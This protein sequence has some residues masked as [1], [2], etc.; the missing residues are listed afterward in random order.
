[1]LSDRAVVVPTGIDLE[2]W[3]PGPKRADGPM[4]ILFV[5]GQFD[6]KGGAV[7]LEAFDHLDRGSAE[8]HVVT[9]STLEPRP[10]VVVH[11][12]VQPNS[13]EIIEL[14]RSADVFVLPSLAEAF[15][16]VVVESC[17]SGLPTIVTDVGGMSEM[18]VDG[19]TGYVIAPGDAGRLAEV[20]RLLVI[21]PATRARLGAAARVRA[22]AIF[23][24]RKNAATVVDQLL[25]AVLS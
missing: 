5:G 22:E 11:Y 12:G 25:E 9:R 15:P 16:N 19:E 14:Y 8:L 1:V 20:L 23:D 18:V 21:D 2:A 24:G 4:R 10:G 6:R 17:A 3:T 7:L 13:P